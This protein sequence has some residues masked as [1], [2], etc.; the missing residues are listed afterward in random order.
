[1]VR[2]IYL[3]RSPN[4]REYLRLDKANRHGLVA[5]VT[6]SGKTT[7]S[8]ALAKSFSDRGVSVFA[9]DIKGDLSGIA[10]PAQIGGRAPP[11]RFFDVFGESGE[12]ITT[13]MT[14]LGPVLLARMMELSDAQTG[15]LNIAF[16]LAQ[17][18]GA[19]VATLEDLRSVL[20]HM[21]DKRKDLAQTFGAISPASTATIIRKLLELETQGAATFFGYP[22][23]DVNS[24]MA[25]DAS[26]RGVV[27]VLMADRLYHQP[28]LY[29]TFLF[30]L[31][32]QL[33]ERLPEVG[34][35]AKPKMVFFFDEAHLLFKD[36]SKPLLDKID[37]TVRLIRSKGVG[38]YFC[39]QSPTDIPNDVLRQL[40]NRFQH[41]LRAYTADDQRMVKAAAKSYRPNPEF[42]AEF[43]MQH[44]ET[45]DALVSTLDEN[46]TPQPVQVTRIKTPPVRIGPL[47]NEE[48]L[49]INARRN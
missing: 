5:G 18:A 14:S 26:G 41:A 17:R 22:S 38:I 15:V 44:L 48:R 8:I 6:G 47:T 42:N 2:D 43:V 10:V 33:F 1:M 24:L 39:T 40:S 7:T 36:A 4:G 16:V 29:S 12:P 32:N 37:Q 3:G 13:T 45:G 34:D 19:D 31:L 9:A 23:F 35:L 20:A 46:G 30:W 21:H 27:N 28:K 49:E 11:V 25:R